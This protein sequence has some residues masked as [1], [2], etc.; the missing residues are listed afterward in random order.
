MCVLKILEIT[1]NIINIFHCVHTTGIWSALVLFL[2]ECF[3][4]P[5]GDEEGGRQGEVGNGARA[6]SLAQP[7]RDG[8]TLICVAI[9]KRRERKV[10]RYTLGR[11]VHVTLGQ[12]RRLKLHQI[13][14]TTVC[15]TPIHTH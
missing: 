1:K 10:Y 14:W 9:Y 6:P 13:R 8:R 2:D 15:I 3:H 7:I 4:E 5:V 11:A 12:G